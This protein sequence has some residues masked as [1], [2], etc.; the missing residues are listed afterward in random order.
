M[1]KLSTTVDALVVA[2]SA[3]RDIAQSLV[4]GEITYAH[5][6]KELRR[7]EATTKKILAKVLS[8]EKIKKLISEEFDKEYLIQ[9]EEHARRVELEARIQD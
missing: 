6:M 5:A 9:L 8:N 1:P 3:I 4:E 7:E 2:N